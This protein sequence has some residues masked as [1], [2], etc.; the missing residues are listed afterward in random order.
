MANNYSDCV[1]T[2]IENVFT[3]NIGVANNT[4]I[5]RYGGGNNVFTFNIGVA[6]NEK[7]NEILYVKM[8]LHLI[9]VWLTTVYSNKEKGQ[10]KEMLKNMGCEDEIL[11]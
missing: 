7:S 10:V 1:S 8:Y 6:N 2:D 4:R 9:L 3:F 5:L 11:K